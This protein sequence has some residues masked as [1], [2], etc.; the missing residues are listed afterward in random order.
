MA[1]QG[2]DRR[3]RLLRVA[4]GDHHGQQAVVL[5]GRVAGAIDTD[6]RMRAG[7]QLVG[8][9]G[10]QVGPTLEHRRL[11]PARQAV[12]EFLSHLEHLGPRGLRQAGTRHVVEHHRD[13][14]LRYLCRLGHVGH[15]RAPGRR[16]RRAGN[17]AK[18][19]ISKPN[20]LLIIPAAPTSADGNWL[21]SAPSLVFT[22][23]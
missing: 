5:P 17:H 12:A 13:S 8:Q 2:P 14:G 9:V 20:R 1:R 4:A 21:S 23:I 18:T 19:W 6:D 15:G 11:D 7:R 10:D 22:P 3:R 16:G